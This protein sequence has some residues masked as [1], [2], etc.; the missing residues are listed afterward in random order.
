MT[1]PTTNIRQCYVFDL[2]G[3]LANC[4]HRLHHI[5]DKS[6]KDWDA[7]FAECAGD[8]PITH[9]VELALTL[10]HA[11]EEIIYVTGRSDQCREETVAWLD[12]Q[13]LPNEPLYMR[14]K[15]DHRND[16]ILKI[17]LLAQA[18][19]DGWEPVMA[20]EDRSRVVAAWRAAGIPCLQVQEGD[21]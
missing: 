17:E 8:A 13:G 19:A 9:M 16:D 12:K 20:F 21:F 1:A 3:T 2:D 14:K 4:D 10:W 6:P 11:G 18:R 15:G 7:Y 5:R